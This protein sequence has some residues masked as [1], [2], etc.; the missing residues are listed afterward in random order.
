M[1]QELNDAKN[2]GE[3]GKGTEEHNR[4]EDPIKAS[5]VSRNDERDKQIREEKGTKRIRSERQSIKEAQKNRH[6][7]L[8]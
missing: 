2:H 5:D 8:L 3:V 7:P 4:V 1:K 6:R